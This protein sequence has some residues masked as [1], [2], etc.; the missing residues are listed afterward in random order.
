MKNPRRFVVCA[1]KNALM[2]Y[3]RLIHTSSIQNV[4]IVLSVTLFLNLQTYGSE[5]SS[6]F[7]NVMTRSVCIVAIVI[8]CYLESFV[9]YARTIS[10]TT[11]LWKLWTSTFIL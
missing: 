1:T 8:I 3:M 5:M 10:L 2:L 4:S 6:C 11:H 9:Q 7:I